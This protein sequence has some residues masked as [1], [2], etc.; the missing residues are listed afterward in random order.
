MCVAEYVLVSGW[1]LPQLSVMGTQLCNN[2]SVSVQL[3]AR[4]ITSVQRVQAEMR[5]EQVSAE[6]EKKIIGARKQ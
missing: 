4:A 3:Q 1:K 5:R 6:E 2:N